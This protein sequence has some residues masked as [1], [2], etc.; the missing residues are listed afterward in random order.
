M[1]LFIIVCVC[2][3]GACQGMWKPLDNFAELALSFHLYLASET[4]TRVS[5][6]A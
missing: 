4:W 6:L 5:R 2:I 1:D 3:M